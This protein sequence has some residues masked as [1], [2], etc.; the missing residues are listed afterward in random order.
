MPFEPEV[1]GYASRPRSVNILRRARATVQHST[2]LVDG[3]GSRSNAA[4]FGR[5]RFFPDDSEACSSRSA[6][7][8]IHTRLGR[9]SMLQKSMVFFWRSLWIGMVFIHFGRNLGHC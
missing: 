2:M 5:S 6:R 9:S 7:L 3:P 1:L 8:A 4:A